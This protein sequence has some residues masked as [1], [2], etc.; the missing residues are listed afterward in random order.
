MWITP[1]GYFVESVCIWDAVEKPVPFPQP[2][3][4]VFNTENP[5]REAKNRTCP[6]HPRP[7]NCN[8][9]INIVKLTLRCTQKSKLSIQKTDRKS[10]TKANTNNTHGDR[11][12]NGRRKK[13]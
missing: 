5:C 6:Q 9:F 13:L 10:E 12:K 8:Y 2:P 3:I 1:C 7:Y 4:Q 11:A